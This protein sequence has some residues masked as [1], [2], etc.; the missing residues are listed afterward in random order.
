LRCESLEDRLAPALFNVQAPLLFTG[1]RNFGCVVVGDLNKDGRPDAVL[2]DFGTGY[3]EIDPNTGQPTVPGTQ[4]FVLRGNASGGFDKLALTTG[5]ENVSFV[6]LADINADGWDDVVA[7]NSNRQNVGSVSVFQNNATAGLSLTKVATFSSSSN[8]PSW[9]G[10]ADFTGDAVPDI[11]VG[12]FGK[13][14]A[15]NISGNGVNIFQG[16]ADGN[17]KG[18]FTY[19]ASPITTLRPV[20]QFIPTALAVADFDGNGKMD[21]AAAVPSVPPDFNQP[22]QNAT[23]YVFEGTGGGGF[24]SSYSEYDSGG[25]L[26]VNIQAADIN[27]DNKADL[28]L[29]NAGD[30]N[31]NPEFKG[32]SV[33]IIENS[34]TIGNVSF[35]FTNTLTANA[36]GTF[37]VAI[38]D[39]NVDGKQ[40]IAA[41][42][43]GAQ[44]LG[45][46][47]F[48][49]VFM[50]DGAGGFTPD[51]TTPN[52]RY[53]TTPNLGGGQYLAVGDFN[54][55]GSPDVIVGHASSQVTVM[56]NTT[57]TPKVESVAINGGAAQRSKV[58]TVAVTFD[59]TVTVNAGAFG[60]TGVSRTGTPLTGVTIGFTTAVVNGKTV[61][62][63]TFGGANV[64]FGSLADGT[65]TLTVNKNL[66]QTAA[67]TRM[68]ANYSQ[69]N[70]KR[71]FGDA[72]GDGDVDNADLFQIFRSFG[73]TTGDTLY[74]A[75][76]DF[77]GDGDVDNF[78]LFRFKQR[79][80][81]SL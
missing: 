46:A 44:F 61:A 28:I 33:G 54:S 37:A 77:D 57:V 14:S 50:G 67:G 48:V 72:D 3:G 74:N 6:T 21:I 5:G 29:A 70:I 73:K 25:V 9:V 15:D 42:N 78:D 66:V 34:S 2:T 1:A 7:V 63:L 30:P 55:D 68:A 39:F 27:G 17:G 47:A 62:T 20:I 64:E 22:N 40:D 60:I 53:V 38:A 23:V 43:Y 4:I 51:T 69:G 26:P 52:G 12:S 16:N 13:G 24:A 41:V 76:L 49:A 75:A 58:T 56:V 11:V 79:F 81:L 32:N 8:N 36:Y 59:T 65:W 31:D 19:G 71:L 80:G 35:G 45:Q 18:N 10:L